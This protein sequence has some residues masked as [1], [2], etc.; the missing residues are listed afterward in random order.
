[1]AEVHLLL[2]I[3]FASG[4]QQQHLL[5][6]DGMSLENVVKQHTVYSSNALHSTEIYLSLGKQQRMPGLP[7]NKKVLC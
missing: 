1:M 2:E 3:L 6:H 4:F 7:A 5:K